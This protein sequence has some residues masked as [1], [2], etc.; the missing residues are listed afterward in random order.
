MQNGK[1]PNFTLART[2]YYDEPLKNNLIQKIQK[3]YGVGFHD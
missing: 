2:Q 3:R 1:T